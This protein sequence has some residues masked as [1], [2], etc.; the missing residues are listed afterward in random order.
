MPPHPLEPSSVEEIGCIER[1]LNSFLRKE[2]SR[3]FLPG[4]TLLAKCSDEL[5][6]FLKHAVIGSSAAILFPVHVQNLSDV[7]STG[8]GS[9][10]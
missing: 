9:S 5:E 10:G 2:L 4:S 6:V 7:A 1:D 3:D 8:L